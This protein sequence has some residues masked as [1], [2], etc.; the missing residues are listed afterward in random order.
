MLYYAVLH[1]AAYDEIYHRIES[2]MVKFMLNITDEP[3]KAFCKH[4]QRIRHSVPSPSNRCPG[5]QVPA[6]V[7]F[8]LAVTID[9]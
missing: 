8:H 2:G 1:Y 7:F 3:Q 9:L 4:V 6:T 5:T